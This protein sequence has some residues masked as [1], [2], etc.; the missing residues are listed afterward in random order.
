MTG[1]ATLT[2]YPA[3]TVTHFALLFHPLT[4]N[5]PFGDG[6]GQAL[7]G[8]P[9][10]VSVVALNA[11]NQVVTDFTGTIHFTSLDSTA[12]ASAKAKG[13]STPLAAFSYTFV[14]SDNGSHLFYLTFDTPGLDAL[15]VLGNQRHGDCQRA[16]Q[17]LAHD[18]NGIS[19]SR[20]RQ[21]Y[22]EISTSS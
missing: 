19:D 22:V 10:A 13:A 9:V 17:S 14:A 2:V 5:G 12:L 6:V 1:Q 4:A 8:I 21:K 16:H 3:A 20:T 15:T 18:H 7:V 11:A